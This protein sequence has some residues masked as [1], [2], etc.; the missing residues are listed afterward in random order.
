MAKEICQ[1]YGR[2][3]EAG[4]KGM[5]CRECIR[6]RQSESAKR[7][8]LNRMGNAAWS[9]K[10]RKDREKH[11]GTG[12]AGGAGGSVAEAKEEAAG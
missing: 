7:R 4:P 5:L 2:I 3:F 12:D 10:R 11:V 8:G 1:D 6:K 9:E